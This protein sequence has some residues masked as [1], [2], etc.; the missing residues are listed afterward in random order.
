MREGS[1]KRAVRAS[2]RYSVWDLDRWT[3][4]SA[5]P[6]TKSLGANPKAMI[7]RALRAGRT[8]EIGFIS[9]GQG[10]QNSLKLRE[11]REVE[12][13]PAPHGVDLSSGA[14]PGDDVLS[15]LECLDGVLTDL[16]DLG[17]QV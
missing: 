17:G 6:Q 10:P 16:K 14:H 15:F 11:G 7:R 8:R 12:V 1:A 2:A 4:S 5:P 9:W 13:R 3:P